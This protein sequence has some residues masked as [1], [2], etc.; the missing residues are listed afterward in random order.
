MAE[1][2]IDPDKA[3]YRE[4]K[5]TTIVYINIWDPFAPKGVKYNPLCL[6]LLY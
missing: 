6:K 4:K 3:I 5:K 2:T 1:S